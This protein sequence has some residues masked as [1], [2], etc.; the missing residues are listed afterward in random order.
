MSE[1]TA[2]RRIAMWSGPR[3]ISTALLRSWESRPDTFVCDEPL[4][5]HYLQHTGLPH[6]D[7][8]EV[9]ATH[10]TDWSK[11]VEWL[12]GEVP[13][14][15]Q[16]FYQKH[17]AHHLL[18]HIEREW[19]DQLTHAFLV[20]D[21]EDM[22]TS[23]IQ[24]TPHPTLSDTGLPQQWELFDRVAQRTGETPPVIDAQDVLEDPPQVLR[25]LCNALEV[26]FL[27]SMLEWEPGPR[28]TDGVWG[29]HW[30]ASLYDSTGFRPFRVKDDK[31][32]GRLEEL[33]DEAR[34]IYI[35]LRRYSL[36]AR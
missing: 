9:I 22:L 23:L 15:K 8:D 7:R 29:K 24:F 31:V 17:M 14:G 19:L 36:R 20:R 2:P 25:K 35:R 26:P 30:Y 6:P 13:Q 33:L 18:P 28:R 27:D 5:A 4:Y 1:Q 16:I 34:T 32:P 10:E 12:T 11:V 3:N 21:P